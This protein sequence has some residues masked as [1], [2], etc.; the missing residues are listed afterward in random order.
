M[1]FSQQQ[2]VDCSWDYG[3]NACD[4]GVQEWAWEYLVDNGGAVLLSQYTYRSQDRFCTIGN[5]T[6]VATLRV[7]IGC[8]LLYAVMS[9]V[10]PSH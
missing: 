9:M 7:R 2:L 8:T 5:A 3:D 4:G 6:P 1:D 10:T